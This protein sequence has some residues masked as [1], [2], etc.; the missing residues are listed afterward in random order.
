MFHK[1]A[2]Y[3][4][5]VVHSHGAATKLGEQLATAWDYILIERLRVHVTAN[6][7]RSRKPDQTE[8]KDWVWF[9]EESDW[10]QRSSQLFA[11]AAQVAERLARPDPAKISDNGGLSSRDS[12]H[13]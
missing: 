1:I 13:P 5:W 3:A 9:A 12:R 6:A 4:R 2:P 7:P 8:K 11:T 10:P